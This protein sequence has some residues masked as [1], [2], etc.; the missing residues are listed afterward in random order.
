MDERPPRRD[1][2]ADELPTLELEI[3]A[4][5][6]RVTAIEQEVAWLRRTAQVW[7]RGRETRPLA[8]GDAD[9]H[10]RLA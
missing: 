2:L 7:A 4:I 10:S 1:K 3:A 5:K 9:G 8:P 6:E